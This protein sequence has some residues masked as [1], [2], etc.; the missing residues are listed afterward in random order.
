MAM[1]FDKLLGMRWLKWLMIP[2][3]LYSVFVGVVFSAMR[4]PPDEF[5]SFMAKLPPFAMY[6]LPFPPLWN[7]ARAGKLEPGASAPDFDLETFDRRGRVRLS[8]HR[9]VRPVV[10]VFGSYT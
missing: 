6:A 8:E 10:L 1:A 2:I 3:G 7:I 9:G 4:R 5:A